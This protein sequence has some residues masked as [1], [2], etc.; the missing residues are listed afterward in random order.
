MISLNWKHEDGKTAVYCF[1]TKAEKTAAVKLLRGYEPQPVQIVERDVEVAP[2]IV[3]KEEHKVALQQKP[4]TRQEIE[5]LVKKWGG[6]VKSRHPKRRLDVE[7]VVLSEL[8]E[9]IVESENDRLNFINIEDN[10]LNEIC[11]QCFQQEYCGQSPLKELPLD[12]VAFSNFKNAIEAGVGLRFYYYDYLSLE[13]V[14][15]LEEWALVGENWLPTESIL[16]CLLAAEK[17][18]AILNVPNLEHFGLYFVENNISQVNIKSGSY[19]KLSSK[20]NYFDDFISLYKIVSLFGK[21]A[22]KYISF[23]NKNFAI[24]EAGR[25]LPITSDP[26]L[27]SWCMKWAPKM[28]YT[29]HKQ[30]CLVTRHWKSFSSQQK[31]ES[32][33]SFEKAVYNATLN[34]LAYCSEQEEFAKEAA[35]WEGFEENQEAFDHAWWVFSQGVNTPN[36]YEG[37]FCDL[38][39][40]YEV[41]FHKREE[42]MIG[43]FGNYTNCCQHYLGVGKQCAYSTVVDSFSQLFTIKSS[44]GEIL[45]GS[46][47]W[48]SKQGLCFDNIESKGLNDFQA[49]A[50]QR[51]YVEAANQLKNHFDKDV[52]VGQ[53]LSKVTFLGYEEVLYKVPNRYHQKWSTNYQR[54]AYTDSEKGQW[55]L[56]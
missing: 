33:N 14:F 25:G 27:A 26:E 7:Q 32:K 55:K 24:G 29:K 41:V 3:S 9:E 30:L 11:L 34:S 36:L 12:K 46:W 53:S 13:R 38:L 43:F 18:M 56:T 5:K 31:K 51:I 20:C 42:V 21:E 48:E 2:Q 15:T 16:S 23:F 10:I 54:L 8:L 52:S 45:C 6:R 28:A 37:D 44:K 35:K 47:L 17:A 49:L 40:G 1:N 22:E 4:V 39:T 19:T 50:C